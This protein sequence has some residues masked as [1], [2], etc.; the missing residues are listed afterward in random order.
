MSEFTHASIVP[1]IG[2]ETIGSHR[3]FGT[4]PIHFM[5]YEAFAA[6]DK[7]IL[8]YYENKIPYYVLDKGMAPPVNERAD[9]VASVCPCAG[10]SM[11]SHGYGD[12]NENNKWMVETTKYILGDYKPKVLW[13]ENAPGFAGKIGKNIREELKQIGKDNGYTM[14]VYRT[15]SLLH[16]VP[17][18]RE[19]SFYFFWKGAQ[20][21]IF[22]YYNREY[23]PIEDL[24]RNVKSNYQMEPINPKKPS[25]NPY[26]KYILEEIHGGRTH[27]EHRESIPLTSARGVCAFSYIESMGHDY[28][29]V[30]KWMAEN[31]F[32]QEVEKCNYK[33]DKLASGKSIMRRGVIVPKDRIGAFVGHYPVMLTHPDEDRFIT[34]REAMSIMGLPED[35][36]LVDASPRNANHI[37]QNVP[38][39][40]AQDM[41]TE[42]LATLRGERTMV[43]TDY[44]LQYNTTN[45]LEYEEQTNT[46]EEFFA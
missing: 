14:S 29:Q 5:S 28:K 34:Y 12:D 7:H 45:K 8:N 27:K 39:Q 22:N 36:E 44:I 46:L 17:Q 38:V 41:A 31:G 6:N 13:G 35:F 11:M 10:L 43:D 3:A 4:P 15:K 23:T 32:E 19:R 30:G 25:D 16:G 24:I 9:V 18:V 37:C 20:V 21:P 26:Y 33:Y 2:G 42:V 40:T 1:L